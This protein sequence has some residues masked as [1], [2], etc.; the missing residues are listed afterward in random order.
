[1]RMHARMYSRRVTISS[2]GELI[3][4]SAAAPRVASL[5]AVH[6]ALREQILNGLIPPGSVLSQVEL[7]DRFGVSRTPLREALRMLQEEGLID[8]RGRR[9]R[10]VAFDLR[11]LEAI[12]AQ[13]ILLSALASSITAPRMTTSDIDAMRGYMTEMELATEGGDGVAWKR[14][15]NAF[16]AVHMA[17]APA[18]INDEISRLIERNAFYQLVWQRNEPH[19][20]T[21]TPI[22]HRRILDACEHA[23][24]M[25]LAHALARHQARIALTAVAHTSPEHDPAIIRGALQVVVGSSRLDLTLT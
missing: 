8:A 21:Q 25:D 17:A 15:D 16:H 3:E 6:R 1:M 19:L 9:A 14:A 5:G 12:S 10:V 11:D 23:N 4:D 18:R 22:D 2:E 24:A 13:R 20:D 7:A